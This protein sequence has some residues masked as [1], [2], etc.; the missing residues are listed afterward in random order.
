MNMPDSEMAQEAI[1]SYEATVHA[2]VAQAKQLTLKEHFSSRFRSDEIN[3]EWIA[4]T[5]NT[6]RTGYGVRGEGKCSIYVFALAE[7]HTEYDVIQAVQNA[8]L[9]RK[10]NEPDKKN[11][12]CAVNARHEGSATLYVGRSFKPQSRI[13][14]HFA[15]SAGGTY[16]MHLEQWALPLAM[17]ID[18]I[19]YDVPEYKDTPEMQ[20]AINVLET[21]M[22]DYLR[23]LLGRR[24][25]K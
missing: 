5:V 2:A 14:Q 3:N 11:N 8:K 19:V 22:W 21:G 15:E 25:D 7:R 1:K 17:T 24:G 20:R 9:L 18:L 10:E 13:K 12:L 16:A 4:E 6:I 23:P